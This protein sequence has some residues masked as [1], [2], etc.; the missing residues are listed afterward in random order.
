MLRDNVGTYRGKEDF[1]TLQ[2]L[3]QQAVGSPLTL[4][5][6]A[7]ALC[8]TVI[9]IYCWGGVIRGLGAFLCCM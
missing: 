7:A 6:A 9:T 1:N 3:K 5:N 2:S 4:I 8:N